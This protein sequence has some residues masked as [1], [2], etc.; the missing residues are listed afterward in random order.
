M[1]ALH[2]GHISIICRAVAETDIVVVS[3]F[4]NP[5][6]FG[7]HEDLEQYPRQW[8]QDCQ[9]CKELGVKVVFAP[10]PQE[11]GMN[12]NLQKLTT[13]VIPPLSMSSSLCG[14]F[15][16]VHFSVVATIITKLLIIVTPDVVF[17]GE[18]DAQQLAIIRQ[19]VKDLNLPVTIESCP[20][21]R[22]S[23]VLAYRSRNQYLSEERKQALALFKG[24]KK[25]QQVFDKGECIT[26]R[27]INIFSQELA[28]NPGVKIQ[29]VNIFIW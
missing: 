12:N 14:A 2:P 15:R 22:E 5:L 3:I 9:L 17:G 27:L 4:V 25:V 16:L 18:K 28:L 6:Q 7:A 29:Y 8:E 13:T 10:T 1:G 26:K 20:I 21:V 24:L 11:M 19:L 23:S